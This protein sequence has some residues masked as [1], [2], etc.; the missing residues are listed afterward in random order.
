VQNDLNFKIHY[1]DWSTLYT[2]LLI[3]K[4]SLLWDTVMNKH[5]KRSIKYKKSIIKWWQNNRDGV[6]KHRHI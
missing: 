1:E 3:V 4:L 6:C 2:S 5:S